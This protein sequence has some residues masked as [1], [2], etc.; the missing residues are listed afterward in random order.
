MELKGYYGFEITHQDMSGSEHHR[1]EKRIMYCRT[2]DERDKWVSGLQHAAHV[3]FLVC[4]VSVC[5]ILVFL[6]DF[7]RYVTKTN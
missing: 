3:S 2:E 7:G 4:C 6:V 1:H 5:F